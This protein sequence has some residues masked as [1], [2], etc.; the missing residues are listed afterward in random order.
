MEERRLHPRF[1][2]AYHILL[3]NHHFG[4]LS[5]KVLNMSDS[6]V[7]VHQITASDFSTGMLLE[8]E[9]IGSSWDNSLPSLTMRVIRVESSGIALEFVELE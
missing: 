8:A 3:W 1:I 5:G 9:I 6:G 7:F 2:P 4:R